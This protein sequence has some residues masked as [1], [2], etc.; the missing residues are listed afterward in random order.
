MTAVLVVWLVDRVAMY[1]EAKI[2]NE[3]ARM[4][5]WGCKC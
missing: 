5:I 3:R 2:H 4:V 1:V